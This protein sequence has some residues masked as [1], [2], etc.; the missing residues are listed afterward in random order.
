MVPLE[1]IV[2][3]LDHFVMKVPD[4][5]LLYPLVLEE[6][7]QQLLNHRVRQEPLIWL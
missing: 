6:D 5:D 4:V 2:R 1:Q 7:S 3:H